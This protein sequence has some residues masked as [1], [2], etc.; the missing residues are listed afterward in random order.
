MPDGLQVFIVGSPR[1]GTSITFYAM[2]KVMQLPG[3]G[4]SHVFPIF[5]RMIHDF[6]RYATEFSEN[7]EVLAH[8]LD[9]RLFKNSLFN[10]I[11]ELYARVYAGN[12]WVDKT[13]GGEG[14]RGIPLIMDAFPDAKIIIARRTGI[15]TV[16]SIR[17]KFS[18]P[19]DHAC[20]IWTVAAKETMQIR[21]L[22]IGVLEVDQFDMTNNPINTGQRLSSFLGHPEKAAEMAEFFASTRTDQLSKHDWSRRVTLDDAGWTD[23]EKEMFVKICGPMMQAF[24]YPM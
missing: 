16:N 1:S 24:G 23:A 14:V 5:Q 19:F 17:K 2:R 4:E 12:R 7:K 20:N 3:L 13:P 21:Q 6:Y 8:N 22:G 9:T 11:R 18:L 10:Y 15:E